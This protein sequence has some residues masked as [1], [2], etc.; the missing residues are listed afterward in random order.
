MKSTSAT[1]SITGSVSGIVT[2]EVT[3]PAAAAW[4]AEANVSRCSAPGS[5]TKTRMSTRPGATIAPRQ[6]T[7]SALAGGVALAASGPAATIRRSAM[8]T[9]PAASRSRDGSMTRALRNTTGRSS[10]SRWGELFIAP[11]SCV[12]QVGGQRL[13]HGHAHGHAH[14]DLLADEALRAV[15]NGGVDLDAAVHRARVHDQRVGPGERQLL[16]IEA[17]EMEVFAYRGNEAAAHALALQAQ[18]HHDV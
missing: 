7:V 15:G 4:P 3:P 1:S 12:R 10:A 5:P 6:S 8:M 18:H 17:E 11:S 14:L 16:R 9:A 13:K 2:I